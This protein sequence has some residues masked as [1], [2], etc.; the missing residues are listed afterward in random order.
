MKK[1]LVALFSVM[2][3]V[4]FTACDNDTQVYADY[5]TSKALVD[6][7]S[8]EKLVGDFKNMLSGTTVTGLETPAIDVQ[9][10]EGDA[11][12]KVVVTLTIA[13]GGYAVSNVENPVKITKGTATVTVYGT[14]NK[15]GDTY[16]SFTATG[17]SITT[18]DVELQNG[19]NKYAFSL[20]VAKTAA[21]VK[22]S[23]AENEFTIA[24]STEEGNP[25]ITIPLGKD[26]D[27]KL[28]DGIVEYERLCADNE[29]SYTPGDKLDLSALIK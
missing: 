27:C 29:P 16:E 2:M 23:Y 24:G 26:V 10:E 8:M 18:K 3:L 20:D 1:I 17:Y 6:A 9:N 25:T 12:D 14:A 15:T 5:E 28:G 22:I 13:E 7:I 4:A 19:D 21:D 11:E